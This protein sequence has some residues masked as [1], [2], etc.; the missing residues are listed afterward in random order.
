[1]ADG[2]L[3]DSNICIYLL[4]NL[5][6]VLTGR[7]RQQEEGTLFISSISYAE[8][9]L[10]AREKPEEQRAL[11]RFVADVPIVAFDADAARIYAGL[12]FRRARFDRLIAAHALSLGQTLVTNNERDFADVPG[13]TVE[14]WTL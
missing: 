5:S 12:T 1:M 7:I 14:N 13:L 8:V 6:P 9:G 4:K 10:G 3:L 2:Y 11:E